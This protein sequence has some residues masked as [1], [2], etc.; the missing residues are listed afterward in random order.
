MGVFASL[1]GSGAQTPM[2]DGRCLTAW[3][4]RALPTPTL[5][6]A[7]VRPPSSARFLDAAAAALSCLPTSTPLSTTLARLAPRP[8]GPRV[9]PL[10]PFSVYGYPPVNRLTILS[11]GVGAHPLTLRLPSPAT[12]PITRQLQRTKSRRSR[13]PFCSPT[14]ASPCSRESALATYFPEYRY[15]GG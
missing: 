7:G 6:A 14:I 10:F 4:A 12:L 2:L 1:P 8:Q 13:P 5:C 3:W 15:P 9:S 11:R